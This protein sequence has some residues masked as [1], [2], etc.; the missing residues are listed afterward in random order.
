MSEVEFEAYRL[1]VRAYRDKFV[2]HLDER[3]EM[4]IPRLEPAL[5]SIY[6]LYAYLLEN[7]DDCDAFN[8]APSDAKA[9]YQEHLAEGRE[10]HAGQ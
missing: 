8:D 1:D 4:D 10:A 6:Y 7:E 2:A 3:N 5:V 9:Q